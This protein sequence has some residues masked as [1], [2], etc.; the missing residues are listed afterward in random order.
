LLSLPQ[1]FQLVY[2]LQHKIYQQADKVP[3]ELKE[4]ISEETYNK[5]RVY[6]LDKSS[7]GI[8]KELFGITTTVVRHYLLQL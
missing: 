4:I 8:V 1:T 6:G 2:C 3:E 5:A 7:F